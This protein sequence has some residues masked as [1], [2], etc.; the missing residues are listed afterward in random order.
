MNDYT[1]DTLVQQTTAEYLEEQLRFLFE[2][3]THPNNCTLDIL[4]FKLM[5][6]FRKILWGIIVTLGVSIIGGLIVNDYAS[7]L[8]QDHQTAKPTTPTKKQ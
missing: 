7:R 1:E 6:R 3:F 4:P 5:R 8:P 2:K